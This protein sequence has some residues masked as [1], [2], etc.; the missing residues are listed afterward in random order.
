LIF[1]ET[2]LETGENV[3]E[4]RRNKNFIKIKSNKVFS[5]EKR[6]K[7]KAKLLEKLEESS[8]HGLPR[9]FKSKLTFLKIFWAICFI[10]AIFT[11]SWMSIDGIIEYFQYDIVSKILK[12]HEA[13]SLFPAVTI[14][15][16]NALATTNAGDLL[17]ET[18]FKYFPSHVND[19]NIFF[20]WS[21]NKRARLAAFD[22]RY[23]DENK[24]LLGFNFSLMLQICLFDENY[25]NP[26][27]FVWSYN[28][29][30]GNCFTFNSGYSQSGDK[31]PLKYTDKAEASLMMI[32]YLPSSE[33]ILS[34][35]EEGLK[36]FIHNNTF[37]P[38]LFSIGGIGLSP[39]KSYEII[40]DRT[41]VNKHPY[42]YSECFVLDKFDSVYY[43]YIKNLNGFYRQ[44]DCFDL[45]YQQQ[46]VANCKCYSLYQINMFNATPCLTNEEI[47]CLNV[48]YNSFKLN[49][50]KQDCYSMC[51]LECDS[52]NYNTYVSSTNFLDQNSISL[53]KKDRENNFTVDFGERLLRV[54]IFNSELSYTLI[55][56]S[57]KYTILDLYSKLGGFLGLFA[58]LSMLSAME[59]FE[60]AVEM[61]LVLLKA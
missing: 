40:V 58:G 25:C 8:S 16:T 41:F 33:N 6:S 27:D 59:L 38:Y 53:F 39:S 19:T 46:I 3:L 51:P 32:F 2:K 15:N 26:S 36:V 22:K 31:I 21:L 23:G 12:V 57:P 14:C 17:N 45:C 44:Q 30:Y 28:L 7:L 48:A 1:F 47:N 29:R 20:I 60:I 5:D 50:N 11:C 24:R 13:K 54:D 10:S 35:A 9:I 42:P 4:I 34:L 43:S 37:K 55:S 56:E 18:I 49:E 61:L 52:I